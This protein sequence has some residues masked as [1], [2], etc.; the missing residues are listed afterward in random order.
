MQAV[1]EEKSTK[2]TL[3]GNERFRQYV[4]HGAKRTNEDKDEHNPSHQMKLV[5]DPIHIELFM[6]KLG[7]PQELGPR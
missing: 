1:R 2:K 7:S 5:E 3:P 4:E 6:K